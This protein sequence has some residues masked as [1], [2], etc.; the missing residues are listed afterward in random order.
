MSVTD[1]ITLGVQPYAS[2]STYSKP[3]NVSHSNELTRHQRI[4]KALRT[5]Q[6]LEAQFF[7]LDFT[8]ALS[9]LSSPSFQSDLFP[10][11]DLVGQAT[12]IK[13]EHKTDSLQEVIIARI[14]VENKVE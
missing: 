2:P 5:I 13:N 3:V 12:H 7:A 6:M 1:K 10:F 4:E 9:K 8:Q 14:A 11:N